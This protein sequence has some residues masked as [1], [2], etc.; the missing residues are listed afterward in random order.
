[1]NPLKRTF[2]RG[3]AL[4]IPLAVLGYVFVRIVGVFEKMITPL[5]GKMGVDRLLGELTLTLLACLLI[6]VLIL[7]LGM[8]MKISLISRLGT[9]MESVILRFIPSLNQLKSIANEKLDLGIAQDTWKPVIML[10]EQKYSPALIIEENDTLITLFVSK[11]TSLKDGEIL[12]TNKGEVRLHP[13]TAHELHM[14][15]KAFGKG[16]LSLIRDV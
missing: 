13:I 10:H 9:D 15:S 12:I 4:A 8:L 5:A 14:C 3:L 11:G 16:F 2:G 1:M 7:F 6:V